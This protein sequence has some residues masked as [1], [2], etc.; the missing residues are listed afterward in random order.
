MIIELSEGKIL[1]VI[2]SYLIFLRPKFAKGD[3]LQ[4]IKTK[5][6]CFAS[7]YYYKV[8]TNILSFQRKCHK[9]KN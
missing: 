3:F 6:S 2:F 1:K 5:S 7:L 4:D 8:Y 9:P